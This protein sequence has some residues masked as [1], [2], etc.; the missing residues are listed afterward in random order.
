VNILETEL[1]DAVAENVSIGDD[2]LVD[3]TRRPY[4]YGVRRVG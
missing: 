2:A 1:S 4:D 3:L